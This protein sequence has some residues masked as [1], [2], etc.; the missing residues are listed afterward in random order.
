MGAGAVPLSSAPGVAHLLA[1]QGYAVDGN[2]H[3]PCAAGGCYPGC[4][5]GYV[6][7][8]LRGFQDRDG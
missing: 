1:C 3:Y 4:G 8:K 5:T 2:R 6:R 7:W